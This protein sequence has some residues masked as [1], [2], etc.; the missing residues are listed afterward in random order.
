[1][2]LVSAL[3]SLLLQTLWKKCLPIFQGQL[4][5][6]MH[7]S[8][9]HTTATRQASSALP[10]P[11]FSFTGCGIPGSLMF[12][13]E[14]LTQAF[15]NTQNIRSLRTTFNFSRLPGRLACPQYIALM[16]RTLADFTGVKRMHFLLSQ[17]TIFSL[18]SSYRYRVE[19]EYKWQR[20][21]ERQREKNILRNRNWEV[22][23]HIH[24]QMVTERGILCP[25]TM[26]QTNSKIHILI[27]LLNLC[28]TAYGHAFP[29]YYALLSK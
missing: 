10:F 11:P 6:Q 5:L 27:S 16:L 22:E 28:K 15:E 23:M 1:M 17:V 4:F 18:Q 20:E 25:Q 8:A 13:R 26:H 2:V 7:T 21:R 14:V 12:G 9:N 3:S 24:T 19:G 29:T